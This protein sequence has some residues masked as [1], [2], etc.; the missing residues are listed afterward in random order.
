MKIHFLIKAYLITWL[1]NCTYVRT[2]CLLIYLYL[3]SVLLAFFLYLMPI[4]VWGRLTLTFSLNSPFEWHCST[5]T[6]QKII[7]LPSWFDLLSKVVFTIAF[8][9]KNNKYSY[10]RKNWMWNNIQ[11]T[12]LT[13]LSS[14]EVCFLEFYCASNLLSFLIRFLPYF[15]RQFVTHC[16]NEGGPWRFYR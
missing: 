13:D 5:M 7:P 10:L 2:Y 4:Y 3:T 6:Q 12:T 15:S 1:N 14:D 11:T 8:W 16:F 9:F